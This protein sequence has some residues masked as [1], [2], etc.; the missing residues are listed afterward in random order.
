MLKKLKT[1][2]KNIENHEEVLEYAEKHLESLESLIKNQENMRWNLRLSK[3]GGPNK[4]DIY[5]AEAQVKTAKKNFGASAHG[6]TAHAAIDELRIELK[7]KIT[8]HKDKRIT[9]FKK[10]AALAKKL[11]RMQ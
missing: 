3:E 1:Q 9:R 4:G 6:E 2:V 10:G 11:L 8:H 5:H 7:R